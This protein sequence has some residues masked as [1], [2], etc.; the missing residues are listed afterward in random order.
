MRLDGGRLVAAVALGALAVCLGCR[1]KPPLERFGLSGEAVML[2]P[3]L[4]IEANLTDI[5]WKKDGALVAESYGDLWIA[6]RFRG[7]VKLDPA[8]GRLT[9]LKPQQNYSGEYQVEIPVG[10]V[11][12]CTSFSLRILDPPRPPLL[13]CTAAGDGVLVSCQPDAQ[14]AAAHVP[15]AYK[16]KYQKS[17]REIPG[18]GSEVYF[19][20]DVDLSESVT[21]VIYLLHANASSSIKLGSCAPT[22]AAPQIRS[23][24]WLLAPFLVLLL[25]GVVFWAWKRGWLNRRRKGIFKLKRKGRSHECEDGTD[26]AE[27]A[28]EAQGLCEEN[29]AGPS[30][31]E[32]SK[33]PSDPGT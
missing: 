5:S 19:E 28:P 11:V 6:P 33:G 2:E 12:Y 21:C 20:K 17:N 18:N 9:L 22:G 4:N 7:R 32:S 1:E 3:D 16:W 25:A 27:A 24:A 10:N 30:G 14:Y 8:T 23:R 29:T 15:P 13:N 31:E 26:A